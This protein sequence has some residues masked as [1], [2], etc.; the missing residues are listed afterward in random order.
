VLAE[1][2][3]VAR[4]KKRYQRRRVVEV[5]RKIVRGTEAAVHLPGSS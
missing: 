1:G 5:V 3:M 2:L 4:V